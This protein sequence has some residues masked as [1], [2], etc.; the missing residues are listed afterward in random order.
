MGAATCWDVVTPD[1]HFVYTN[2]AGSSNISGFAVGSNGSLAPLPNTVQVANP[3]G[4]AN[5][6]IAI[7]SDGK[8]LYSLNAGIGTIGIFAIHNDGT[9]ASLGAIGGVVAKGGFNGIAAY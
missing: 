5:I 2:N 1:G 4:S 9:L 7:S 3:D 6:D 8:F